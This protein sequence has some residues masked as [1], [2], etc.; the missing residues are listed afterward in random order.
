MRHFADSKLA[1]Q[2]TVLWKVAFNAKP[3][4]PKLPPT[5]YSAMQQHGQNVSHRANDPPNYWLYTKSYTPSAALSQEK[6]LN[7]AGSVFGGA[8]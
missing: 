3:A 5:Y 1:Q 4:L 8:L 2:R 7:E 6:T